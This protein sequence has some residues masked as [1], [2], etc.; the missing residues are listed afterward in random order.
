MYE[1]FILPHKTPAQYTEVAPTEAVVIQVLC[2]KPLFLR[3]PCSSESHRLSASFPQL[4]SEV[5]A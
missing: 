4:I 1:K 2:P 3:M 5:D